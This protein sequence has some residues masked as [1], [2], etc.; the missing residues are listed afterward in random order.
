MVWKNTNKHEKRVQEAKVHIE[1]LVFRGMTKPT[2][3]FYNINNTMALNFIFITFIL[4][5]YIDIILLHIN[6]LD[7]ILQKIKN[8]D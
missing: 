1:S 4:L 3:R 5:Q 2:I 8:T 6:F 7:V